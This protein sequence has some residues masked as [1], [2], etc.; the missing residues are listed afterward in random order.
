MGKIHVN[1]TQNVQ[2]EHPAASIGNRI[3]AQLFDFLMIFVYGIFMAVVIGIFGI[4]SNSVILILFLPALFYSFI[5][6][7]IFQG[8]SLGKML[9]KIKVVK[10]DG[11]QASIL[12]YFI[13]WIFRLIEI[14]FYGSVA[15]VTIAIN[16]KGQRLGDLAAGTTVINIKKSFSLN[17][18]VYKTLPDNYELKFQNVEL[19]E[20]KDIATINDVLNFYKKNQN[21]GLRSKYLFKTFDAVTKKT[22]IKTNLSPIEFLQIVIKDYN[23]IIKSSVNQ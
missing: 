17:S 11:S 12:N 18:S 19:L 10:K 1:T 2:I 21:P 16:G 13:R 22:G 20:E 7:N 5:F 3:L 15:I 4:E 8:Q 6:E 9:A 23:Y 14:P